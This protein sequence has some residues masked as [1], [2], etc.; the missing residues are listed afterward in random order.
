[1][2]RRIFPR[3]LLPPEK[4]G[5]PARLEYDV[6]ISSLCVESVARTSAEYK[7]GV[8][9]LAK[10]VKP[11][12]HL[13]IQAVELLS[14]P[15]VYVVGDVIFQSFSV[16]TELAVEAMTEA[17][18]SNVTVEKLPDVPSGA[19]MWRPIFFKGMKREASQ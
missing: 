3:S 17:G 1:M 2:P 14:G 5:G 11:G 9:T 19:S 15:E 6:V 4:Y 12:G 18:M 16:T 13:L 7:R 10:F 8:K